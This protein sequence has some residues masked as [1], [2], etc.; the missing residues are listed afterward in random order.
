MRAARASLAREVT[1][2][3]TFDWRRN[4]SS[5]GGVGL[6]GSSAGGWSARAA[7]LHAGEP[8]ARRRVLGVWAEVPQV[9]SR[10]GPH[11]PRFPH[12]G[13]PDRWRSV[14]VALALS[15]SPQSGPEQVPTLAEGVGA[16]SALVWWSSG[17]GGEADCFAGRPMP[18]LSPGGGGWGSCGGN[19]G[20]A[21]VTHLWLSHLASFPG[22]FLEWVLCMVKSTL[23]FL[24]HSS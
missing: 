3:H 21:K 22:F 16:D 6:V 4:R 20:Q 15:F 18:A 24:R 14:S 19:S 13:L 7:Q 1:W 17:C 5:G 2:L 8:E 11:L 9:W 12:P 10:P 23:T